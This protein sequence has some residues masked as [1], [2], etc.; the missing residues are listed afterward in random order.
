M[1]FLTAKQREALTA[2]ASGATP[3][4]ASQA[5]EHLTRGALIRRG[6]V[7]PGTNTVTP[8][9]HAALA[10]SALYDNWPEADTAKLAELWAEGMLSKAIADVLGRR[11]PQVDRKARTM[12]LPPRHEFGVGRGKVAVRISVS[13]DLY[14]HLAKRA[15]DRRSTISAYVRYLCYRDTGF[16]IK[17]PQDGRRKN[18]S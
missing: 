6:C 8:V 13:P 11:K 16:A 1:A 3:V 14:D 17:A 15:R 4:F 9:G 5:A 7:V 10:R 2:M 18:G 12:G